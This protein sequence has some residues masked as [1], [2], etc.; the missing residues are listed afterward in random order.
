MYALARMLPASLSPD[1][2]IGPNSPVV[3]AL[4]PQQDVAERS[5]RPF[6]KEDQGAAG[7]IA[8]H[9]HQHRGDDLVGAAD[10]VGH[11]LERPHVDLGHGDHDRA[12]GHLRQRRGR[13]AGA[14]VGHLAQRVELQLLQVPHVF[15][16]SPPYS[17]A[18]A[19]RM[20]AGAPSA[21]I[22]APPTNGGMPRGASNGCDHDV[23]LSQ[24]RVHHQRGPALADLQDHRRPPGRRGRAAAAD[25]GRAGAPSGSPG[26]A[27]P[28][29]RGSAAP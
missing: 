18:A 19:S 16:G 5:G 17:S 24:Q 25:A 14:D 2:S 8:H 13:V 27:P 12:V 28:A 11:V 20:S 21:R 22:V 9:V 29:P 3:P 4:A 23:L 26:P 1:C 15:H 10:Q 7:E 6:G